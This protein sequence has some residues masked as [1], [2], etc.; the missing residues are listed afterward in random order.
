MIINTIDKSGAYL[1][2]NYELVRYDAVC[3][4]FHSEYFES[5]EEIKN[6]LYDDKTIILTGGKY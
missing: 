2:G 1:N 4:K 5:I 3:G 6:K